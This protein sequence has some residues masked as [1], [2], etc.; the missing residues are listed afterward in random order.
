METGDAFGEALLEHLAGG[1][2]AYMVERDDGLVEVLRS[3]DPY[4][5]GV[6]AFAEVEA[7]A[8]E[9]VTGR[10]LDIGAGA[11]RFSLAAVRRG[12]DVVALDN[13]I[14]AVE[15]CR[16]RGLTDVVHASIHRYE[17]DTRFDT[18]LMMGAN[19]GLLAP[20]PVQTLLRLRSMAN[21]GAEIIGSTLDPY[22][23][24]DPAHLAYH[25]A[26]RERGRLP[27]HVVMRIRRRAT[28]GKWFDYLF[29]SPDELTTIAERS[30]WSM[31]VV[32]HDGVRYIARLTTASPRQG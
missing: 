32:D 18:F 26:N 8:M 29:T 13:S 10:V 17:S 19:L 3:V 5:A 12:C 14:G 30:G 2:G 20:D 24:E 28:I 31:D 23:T 21:D 25:E 4:F 15:V 27:G 1:D 16:R 9:F 11:G 6:E 7:A 22:A